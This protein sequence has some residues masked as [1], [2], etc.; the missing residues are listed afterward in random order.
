MGF[1]IPALLTK[2]TGFFPFGALW[3]PFL[4]AF[5]SMGALSIGPILTT[6]A[7]TVNCNES[8]ETCKKNRDNSKIAGPIFI[9]VF[10]LASA[11]GLWTLK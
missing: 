8:D 1:S 4:V 9:V 7:Y 3:G 2:L 10:Y 5:I 6:W 11:L